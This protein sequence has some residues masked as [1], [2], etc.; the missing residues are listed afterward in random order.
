MLAERA[1]GVGLGTVTVAK[2]RIDTQPDRM[3]GAGAGDLGNHVDRS[4]IDRNA[5]HG[6]ARQGW[7]V[8]QISR[9]DDLRRLTIWL[10]PGRE[11]SLDLTARYC[12]DDDSMTAHEPQH[13]EIAVRL[14]GEADR[15]ELPELSNLALD[16]I[17][18]VQPERR[19]DRSGNAS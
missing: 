19:P 13:T 15:V 5:Q 10:V 14:L 18:V 11:G 1:A 2:T 4:A 16:H 3:S 7:V 8:D 17:G 9:E 6:Q 12:V